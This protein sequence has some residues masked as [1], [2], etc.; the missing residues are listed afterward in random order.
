MG[1]R[2]DWSLINWV[3]APQW[4]SGR[5]ND[6]ASESKRYGNAGMKRGNKYRFNPNPTRSSHPGCVIA[7]QSMKD[8]KNHLDRI[9]VSVK[10]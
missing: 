10:V 5:S 7:Q 1:V 8:K 4:S 2:A 9:N 6:G 3:M